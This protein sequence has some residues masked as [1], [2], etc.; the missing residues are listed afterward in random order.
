M[1]QVIAQL[2]AIYKKTLDE[3]D[4]DELLT[5]IEAW[6]DEDNFL[7]IINLMD[8]LPIYYRSPL[9]LMEQARACINLYWQNKILDN[10][11]YLHKALQIYKD[12]EPFITHDDTY[13]LDE[14]Q[15]HYHVGYAYFY[16]NDPI[17]AQKHLSYS[18]DYK[19]EHELLVKINHALTKNISTH[20]ADLGG[21]GGVE[22]VLEDF[23]NMLGEYAPKVQSSFNPPASEDELNAF[24]KRLGLSLPDNFRTLYRTFN[25]QK[26]G[27]RFS[28]KETLHRFLNLEEIEMVKQQYIKK[29]CQ[30]YGDD[31]QN[32]HLSRSN[33]VFSDHIKNRLYHN[34]W[35]PI[36][37]SEE[38]PDNMDEMSLLC[39]DL[40]PNDEGQIGQPI[41]V[42][43]DELP[44][45]YYVL[46]YCPSLQQLFYQ[47]IHEMDS[48]RLIY[49]EDAL[50]LVEKDPT[51]IK[52]KSDTYFYSADEKHALE[53]YIT[54]TFGQI[55]D[56]FHEIIS[57]DIECS[58]YII[59]PTDSQ[60]Y[61]TLITGGMGAYQMNTPDINTPSRA[62]LIIRV[63]S[64][65]DLTSNKEKDY[66]PIRWLKNLARQPLY[67]DSHLVSGHTL[68][69]YTLADTDF[70]GLLLLEADD[71]Q[72]NIACTML[73]DDKFIL[74]YQL[75]PLYRQELQ[76]KLDCGLISLMQKLEHAGIP[77][78]PVVDTHRINV[79]ADYQPKDE[80]L[81]VFDGVFWTFNDVVYDELCD[82]YEA[83]YSH[84]NELDNPL[85]QF[86]PLQILF[87]NT[88]VYVMYEA[89]LEF[90]DDLHEHEFLENPHILTNKY[91]DHPQAVPIVS[92]ICSDSTQMG[93]LELLYKVHNS[94]ANKRIG[95]RVF[96][97]GFYKIGVINDDDIDAPVLTIL[98]G[99]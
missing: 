15:W 44:E 38:D 49:D 99:S 10:I 67:Q 39:L 57:V 83:I 29:L 66:W 37:M 61:Y 69:T 20:E 53:Q 96:F 27:V 58:I 48:D 35:L 60:P 41:T 72:D 30:E 26:F 8:E 11:P 80:S 71:P 3:M 98:L 24:E 28:N 2:E 1:T 55:S 89:Y 84:N 7:P 42:H 97:E 91:D 56:V 46:S 90:T 92:K 23:F 16:L 95:E 93:A 54:D 59:N 50:C 70:E 62:E 25:G 17:N 43:F 19:N 82:F 13:A 86:D 63:P 51:P 5:A 14:K 79:C 75:I 45:F 12:I 77:Y 33:V 31:W 9:L 18:Q 64:H 52:Q 74:F 65:W 36:A 4:E 47:L 85:L 87:N 68:T 94:L 40:D 88:C 73:S 6:D 76:Y 34:A 78:P 21:Q 81:A 32:I 22:Y